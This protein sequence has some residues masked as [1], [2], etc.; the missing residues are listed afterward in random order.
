MLAFAFHSHLISLIPI[1]PSIVSQAANQPEPGAVIH[2]A[3]IAKSGPE[4]RSKRKF[5]LTV[6]CDRVDR[7]LRRTGTTPKRR[8]EGPGPAKMAP[9]EKN[10]M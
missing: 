10:Q 7:R 9:L 2:V 1:F 5:R 6:A 3:K 8:E 4:D